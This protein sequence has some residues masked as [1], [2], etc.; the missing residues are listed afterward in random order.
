MPKS[1]VDESPR[2]TPDWDIIPPASPPRVPFLNEETKILQGLRYSSDSSAGLWGD[3][4]LVG[5]NSVFIGKSFF[6]NL[7]NSWEWSGLGR[8]C[9]HVLRKPGGV[10]VVFFESL[11]LALEDKFVTGGLGRTGVS[12]IDPDAWRLREA[13]LSPK[14][15]AR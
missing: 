13:S 2:I 7:P 4:P 10:D 11:L 14:A 3:L 1:R 5:P 6:L 9:R 15:L 12:P 8:P